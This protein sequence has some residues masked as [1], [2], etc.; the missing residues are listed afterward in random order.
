MAR[1]I[2]KLPPAS[3]SSVKARIEGYDV[4]AIPFSWNESWEVYELRLRNHVGLHVDRLP[5]RGAVISMKH[6][7]FKTKG[8]YRVWAVESD[9]VSGRILTIRTEKQRPGKRAKKA[10]ARRPSKSFS[11]SEQNRR[12]A[13]ALKRAT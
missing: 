4:V 6:K 3:M 7:V 11:Q 1:T 10:V 13:A 8:K 9:G 2:G 12:L 5:R